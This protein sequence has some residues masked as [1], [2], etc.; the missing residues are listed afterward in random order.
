MIIDVC[1]IVGDDKVGDQFI[2][3]IQI[4]R[5]K[6]GV[7]F[8]YIKK[9]IAPGVN[10]GDSHNGVVGTTVKRMRA[11]SGYTFRDRDV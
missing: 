5:I 4:E 11:D 9:N 2:I 7:V 3:Q 8:F 6:C 1:H 10:V